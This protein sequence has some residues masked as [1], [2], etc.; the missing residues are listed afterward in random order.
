MAILT[1]LVFMLAVYSVSCETSCI[2]GCTCEVD[3][4]VCFELTAL[5]QPFKTSAQR[6]EI[7]L[8]SLPEIPPNAFKDALNVQYFHFRQV[9][10]GVIKPCA[11][12]SLGTGFD[13]ELCE[14]GTIEA[15]AFNNMHGSGTKDFSLSSST[16]SRIE[17]FAFTNIQGFSLFQMHSTEV[18]LIQS[19]AMYKFSN[20]DEFMMFDMNITEMQSSAISDVTNVKTMD[21]YHATFNYLEC[22]TV[23]TLRS[24]MG[25]NFSFH[26]FRVNCDC[27]LVWLLE[28]SQRD[29]DLKLEDVMCYKPASLHHVHLKSLTAT[30]LCS[31]MSVPNCQNL[32]PTPPT[33][34]TSDVN[35]GNALVS[36]VFIIYLMCYSVSM[37]AQ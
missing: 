32:S 3:R 25:S 28:A 9:S 26:S 31:S 5:P 21:I 8:S 15:N 16:I 36:S 27:G 22:N 12:P 11:F 37:L 1:V 13:F 33:S 19:F 18:E 4:I 17:S 2:T 24:Q 34:C 10:I 23:E 14:I 29:S 6:V 35:A 7:Y 20:I 30:D